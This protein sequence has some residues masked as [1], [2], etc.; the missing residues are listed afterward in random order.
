MQDQSLGPLARSSAS[1]LAVKIA[2]HRVVAH[3][4]VVNLTEIFASSSAFSS[5][6][7]VFTVFLSNIIV[8]GMYIRY[9]VLLFQNSLVEITELKNSRSIKK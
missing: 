3:M 1:G 9:F 6:H 7:F 5:A 4:F 8:E 2:S